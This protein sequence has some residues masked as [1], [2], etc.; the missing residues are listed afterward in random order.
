MA[1]ASSHVAPEVAGL[2]FR[3]RSLSSA[4]AGLFLLDSSSD[5]LALLPD[6]SVFDAAVDLFFF[7]ASL[8]V[9][10]TPTVPD[11][12]SLTLS[13]SSDSSTGSAQRRFADLGSEKLLDRALLTLLVSSSAVPFRKVP[14]FFPEEVTSSPAASSAPPFSLDASLEVLLEDLRI[15][16]LRMSPLAPSPLEVEPSL[17]IAAGV[18]SSSFEGALVDGGSSS[19]SSLTFSRVS[20][21][22]STVVHLR[23]LL[24]GAIHAA[25]P[26][27]SSSS[28]VFLDRDS[29]ASW[30]FGPL[31]AFA[32]L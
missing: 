10:P 5:V 3:S 16:C 11:S 12:V 7:L 22:S 2:F 23:L 19:S 24:D 30:A 1:V 20:S 25:S 17:V 9:V 31:L 4:I 21:A 29:S 15:W 8:G 28:S 27:A 13:R 26:V 14:P 6:P 32:P 18:D